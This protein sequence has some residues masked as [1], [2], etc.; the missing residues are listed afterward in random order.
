M[1]IVSDNSATNEMIDVVS[2]EDVNSTM[3]SL[4][5]NHT[6]LRRKMM[7]EAGG[8]FPFDRDNL[9]SPRD[10]ITLL[11]EIY[12][13]RHLSRRS[14]D[15]MLEILKQQQFTEK[16]PRYLPSN[17][18]FAIKS[19]TVKGVSNDSGIVFLKK[20]IAISVMC[21]DLQHSAIGS[22][23]IAAIGRAIYEYYS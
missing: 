4:G 2:M 5:L 14:C 8:G 6:A 13:A 11:K 19:G 1:I 16:I 12:S 3:R 7:G 9:M 15:A 20:P 18:S 22:D 23:A 17:I 10:S 21:M